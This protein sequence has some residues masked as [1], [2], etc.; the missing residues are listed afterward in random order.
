LFV[1][2]AAMRE[3]LAWCAGRW[4]VLVILGVAAAQAQTTTSSIPAI[5]SAIR[6]QRYDEA[7]Q[8]THAALQDQ[9]T[10]FRIWTLQG[11]AYSLKDDSADALKAFDRALSLSPRYVPAL[12]AKVQI[13][14]RAQDRRAIPTLEQLLKTDP[15]DPTAH[16]MLGTLE[17]KTG[18]CESAVGDF[19]ASGNTIVSHPGS[20]EL[21]GYCLQDTH[22]TQKAIATF[23]RL[24]AAFPE[25]TYPK[26]DLAVL[27]VESKQ[28][29]AALKI[30][31]PLLAADHPDPDA[32]SL[33]SQAYEASGNTSKAVASLRQAIVLNPADPDYYTAFALLCLDHDSYQVGI[34]MLNLGL[35]Q[36]PSDSSLYVSRGLLYAQLGQYDQAEADFRKAESLDAGQSLTSYAMDLAELERDRPDVALAKVR[37]QSKAHPDSAEHHY[38]LAKLLENDASAGPGLARTEAISA[39]QVAV[40][41]KPDFVGA[42]D[43]LASLYIS[44]GQFD[45]AREQCE[46]SLKDDPLDQTALYHLIVV[47][48]HS[49]SSADRERIIGLIKRLAEVQRLGRQRDANRKRFQLVEEKP[50]Q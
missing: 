28:T 5:E 19:L 44:S 22:E 31:E 24:A 45:L 2:L 40:K 27:L 29:E 10:D 37:V 36:I 8:L 47:L 23:Q 3:R 16:E 30:L 6:S 32:L 43:L 38:L 48:R 20:L 39:A 34:T 15:H 21:Y 9:R 11:I 13:L 49:G 35:Q 50:G 42:R 46:S 4:A 17:A 18:K 12:K 7:L 26:Y 14:Y 41:L 33:A 1:S 25:Q